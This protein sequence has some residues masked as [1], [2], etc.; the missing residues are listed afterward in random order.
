MGPELRRVADAWDREYQRARYFGEEPVA[1]VQD[2]AAAVRTHRFAEAPRAL[3]IGC[4]NGRNF[5]AL[6][7]A[8]LDLFGCDVSP[9]AIR[10]L[11]RRTPWAATRVFV[12]GVAAT[13]PNAFEVVIGIQVFQHGDERTCHRHIIEAQRRVAPGGLLAMRVNALGTDIEFAHDLV[14]PSTGSDGF[15]IRYRDGPKA[16]LQIRFFSEPELR[17]LF[18][19]DFV[20]V[21][22]PRRRSTR[23]DPPA[24]GQWCQWEAIWRKRRT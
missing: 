18:E 7:H 15:T 9:D 13:L 14:E 17:A 11:V 2:I 22:P 16:G 19:H 6:A 20:E 8:G 23:R 12:G 1:F 10:S 4:G 21:L 3:D 24:Q 5:T